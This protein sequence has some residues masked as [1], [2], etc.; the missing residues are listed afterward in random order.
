MTV[1]WMVFQ[2]SISGV[3]M[4]LGDVVALYEQP[5]VEV[6]RRLLDAGENG[7]AAERQVVL[8]VYPLP[9]NNL[10]AAGRGGI[11]AC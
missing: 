6:R 11:A 5:G 3:S 4:S 9:A 7:D 10:T 8:L 1:S 2:S